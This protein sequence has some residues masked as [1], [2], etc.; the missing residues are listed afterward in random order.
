MSKIKKNHSNEFKLKVAI[1]AHT[2][3][4]T[5]PQMCH[6]F[7]VASSQIYAWKTKLKEHGASIFS[8]K[9][10]DDKNAEIDRLHQLIGK[11]TAERDFLS[12]ALNR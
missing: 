9:K 4:K 7:G 3:T 10:R 11:I 8:E 12:H 6:E 1:A 2:G 5:V